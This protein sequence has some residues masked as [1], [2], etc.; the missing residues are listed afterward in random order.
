MWQGALWG[1]VAGGFSSYYAAKN[2]GINPWN[3]KSTSM[4]SNQIDI[5]AQDIDITAQ[6]LE[7]SSTVQRIQNGEKL[8]Y[9]NDGSYFE[10]RENILPQREVGYYK[11][12]V[13]PT[14]GING[15]GA[16]RII[17]GGSNEW[18]YSPDHYKT[19]IRFIYYKK[20]EKI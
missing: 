15:P 13:H 7:L 14:P 19:F 1:C 12:Y 2:A 3:G 17:I 6:D 10:N 18:Y 4:G 8:S 20:H 16:Q 5:T 9:R 11:E